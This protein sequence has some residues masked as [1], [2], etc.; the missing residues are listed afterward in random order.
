MAGSEMT[1]YWIKNN[2]VK[3]SNP[4]V[5]ATVYRK[6]GKAIIAVASWAK[7]PV[8]A[9]LVIDWKALGLNPAK[10]R[11]RAPSIPGIQ[12]ETSFRPGERVPF[13]PGRGWILIVE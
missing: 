13:E 10:A 3:P 6:P 9:D 7:G 1:G 12:L 8:F 11:I 2:P 5:L 4:E